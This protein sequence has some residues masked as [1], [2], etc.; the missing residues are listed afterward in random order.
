MR[1]SHIKGR[2]R[3]QS[4]ETAE[5]QTDTLYIVGYFVYCRSDREVGGTGS[6]IQVI[7]R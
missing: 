3:M 5:C 2:C 1:Q 4:R 6:E 7:D